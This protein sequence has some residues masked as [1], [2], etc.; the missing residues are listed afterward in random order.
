MSIE[1]KIREALKKDKKLREATKWDPESQPNIFELSN[2]LKKSGY[3]LV[4]VMISSEGLSPE[5]ILEP[6]KPG[7]LYPDISYDINDKHFY[8]NVPEHGLLVSSDVEGIILGYENALAVVKHL[9][10]LDL[11]EIESELVSDEE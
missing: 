11:D 7:Y 9:E 1:S 3:R 8:I 4:D 6:L 10:S 5:I 2:F